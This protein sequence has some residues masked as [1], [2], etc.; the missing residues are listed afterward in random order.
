MPRKATKLRARSYYL[1]HA[2]N[3]ESFHSTAVFLTVSDFTKFY[4]TGLVGLLYLLGEINTQVIDRR[5]REIK[6][7]VLPRITINPKENE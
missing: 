1:A 2:R 7:N 3:S 4:I 6:H 5:C